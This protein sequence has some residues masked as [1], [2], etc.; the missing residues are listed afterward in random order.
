MR[1]VLSL[2]SQGRRSTVPSAGMKKPKCRLG[3]FLP[4]HR[5]HN[6]AFSQ[7]ICHI[8]CNYSFSSAAIR[9]KSGSY[10]MQRAKQTKA[11]RY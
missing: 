9:R 7:Q 2:V 11:G 5:S 8:V 4:I 10:A 3:A 1:V 6:T